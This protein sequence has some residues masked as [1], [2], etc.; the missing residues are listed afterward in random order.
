MPKDGPVSR[1]PPLPAQYHKRQNLS[2]KVA[3]GSAK[4]KLR[5]DAG[6]SE[7]NSICDDHALESKPE[8][9]ACAF[10]RIEPEEF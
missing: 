8:N 4:L 5:W 6:S 2:Y 7:H 1:L 9:F 3:E 10:F